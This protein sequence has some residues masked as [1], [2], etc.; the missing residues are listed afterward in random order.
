ASPFLNLGNP[1]T[2]NIHSRDPG[3]H[4]T[5]QQRTQLNDAAYERIP[6]QIF[7]L[8]RLDS[9]P[10][11]VIYSYGQALKPAPRSIVTSGPFFGMCTNYQATAEVATRTVVRIDGAPDHP[12]AVIE[13]FNVLQP[14]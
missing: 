11:F 5:P 9:S 12:H 10:R 2:I 3:Q 7:G 6:Q 4:L 14:D 13:A 1:G 8:L